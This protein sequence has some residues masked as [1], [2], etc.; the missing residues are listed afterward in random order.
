MADNCTYAMKSF[1]GSVRITVDSIRDSIREAEW[2][3]YEVD[4]EWSRFCSFGPKDIGSVWEQIGAI[5]KRRRIDMIA[6][7]KTMAEKMSEHMENGVFKGSF[8]ESIYGI[9]VFI[10]PFVGDCEAVA[11]RNH[12]S[13][14]CAVRM[15]IQPTF[16]P[17]SFK[18]MSVLCRDSS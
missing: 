1:G 18:V 15:P 13:H 4:P 12:V 9:P 16:R 8:P 6:I 2:L 14:E 11:V 17:S 10:S 5:R 3:N 7:S